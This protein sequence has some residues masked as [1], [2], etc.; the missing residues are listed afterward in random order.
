MKKKY[1]DHDFEIQKVSITKE[2]T[3]VGYG[4]KIQTKGCPPYYDGVVE[5]EELYDT[6]Q[7]AEFAAIGHITILENG[8]G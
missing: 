7:E 3:H 1:S 8:E 6:A 2:I 4:Y 5:S